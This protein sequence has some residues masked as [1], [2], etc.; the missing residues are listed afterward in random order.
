MNCWYRYQAVIIGTESGN[1]CTL[2]F[3]RFRR[4][5]DAEHWVETMNASPQGSDLTR[6]DFEELPVEVDLVRNLLGV[7][8]AIVYC[9]GILTGLLLSAVQLPG[10][11][12]APVSLLLSSMFWVGLYRTKKKP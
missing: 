6:F 1:R 10:V 7:F 3:A 11:W 5:K 9:G 8:L 12:W 4:Q 2:P